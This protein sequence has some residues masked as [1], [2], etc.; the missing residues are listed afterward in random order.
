MSVEGILA[1]KEQYS[2]PRN[3]RPLREK[4]VRDIALLRQLL[5]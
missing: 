2:L 1:M 5:D 3:R 4:D